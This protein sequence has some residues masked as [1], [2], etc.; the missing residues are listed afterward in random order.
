[1]S[2]FID[3]EPPMPAET[4]YPPFDGHCQSSIILLGVSGAGKTEVGRYLSQHLN[5]AFV[6][7][8]NR[9]EQRLG[10]SRT[11]A[12]ISHVK[13]YE[14]THREVTREILSMS[15]HLPPAIYALAPSPSVTQEALKSLSHVADQGCL[16]VELVADVSEVS[17]RMGLN[18]PRSVALGAPRAMLSKM[19][20]EMHK[21]HASVAN[22]NVNTVGRRIADIGQEIV[23]AL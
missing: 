16:V 23:A 4:T 9:V 20:A 10:I 14:E 22:V 11:T 21:A 7:A 6:D 17:R 2:Q 5:L 1:M 15:I 18:A 3:V 19:I 12:V 13:D 8:D